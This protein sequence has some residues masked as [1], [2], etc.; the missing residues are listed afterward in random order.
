MPPRYL[1]IVAESG[2]DQTPLI[3]DVVARILRLTDLRIALAAEGLILFANDDA[4]PI[5]FDGAKGTIVGT[6][7]A[8]TSGSSQLHAVSWLAQARIVGSNGRSLMADHWGGYVAFLRDQKQP[9]WH[10]VRAPLGPLSCYYVRHRGLTLVTSDMSLLHAA[11]LH[12]FEVDWS[13]IARH[14]HSDQLREAPTALAGVAELVGG[15]SLRVGSDRCEP[16][17]L[18]TPWDFVAP[19]SMIKDEAEAAHLV[20]DVTV[21]CVGSWA[22]TASHVLL[23]LSGGLDSSIVAACLARHGAA[24]SCLTLV[25]TDKSGDERDY[26]RMMAD[27]VGATLFEEFR[28]V[29]RVDVSRSD[30][31]HL[32]R[33]VA[34]SFAQE[35]DRLNVA[36]AERIGATAFFSGAGGDNIF[37]F[38]QSVAPIAD[39][40]RIEGIDRRTWSTVKDICSLAGCDAWTAASR[41]VRRA[42][43]DPPD[44]R[45]PSDPSFL[46]VNTVRAVEGSW[47]HPWLRVPEGGLPGKAA[48]IALILHIQNYLEGFARERTALVLAPLLSQPIVETC[49]RVPSWM[50]CAGGQNR[51]VARKAFAPALPPAIVDRRSKG[52]PDSF[53]AEIFEANRDTIRSMLT[54]GHLA[55]EGL[56][57]VVQLEEFFSDDSRMRG[58]EYFRIMTLADA[59][60]W[61]T[62]WSCSQGAAQAAFAARC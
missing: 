30:A 25:T 45:W 14:L 34:R 27:A 8:G 23:G 15:Y 60:A 35:S 47:T 58:P 24:F 3:D 44:Y 22:S 17:Q 19:A 6:L 61:A 12:Q 28:D 1:A 56:L 62:S 55:G 50:W 51:A 11:G 31:A 10:V 37:C 33:P 2:E 42:W 4:S 49:L 16:V 53:I 43:L 5:I 54:R 46:T 26:A 59:E 9:F 52:T 13:A 48:H 41:G 18:W 36:V 39:R 32:P 57:D 38:L 29:S 7:F 40:L 21:G 20:R